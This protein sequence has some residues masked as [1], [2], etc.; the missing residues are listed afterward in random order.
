MQYLILA[1]FIVLVFASVLTYMYVN[2]KEI[3]KRA[4]ERNKRQEDRI[5]KRYGTQRFRLTDKVT[6]LNKS[7]YNRPDCYGVVKY[8]HSYYESEGLYLY[9]YGVEVYVN[10]KHVE[11][12]SFSS[13]DLQLMTEPQETARQ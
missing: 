4:S 1:G 9:S 3:D 7:F 10:G 11:T 13:D 5:H 2:A 8:E 6:I 12:S